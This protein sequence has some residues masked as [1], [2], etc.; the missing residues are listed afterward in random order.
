MEND[1]NENHVNEFIEINSYSTSILMLKKTILFLST[2]Q[3]RVHELF[4]LIY[5]GWFL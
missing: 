5:D 4:L 2:W 3:L 1:S